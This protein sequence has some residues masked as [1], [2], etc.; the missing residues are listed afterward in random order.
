MDVDVAVVW[1]VSVVE[2][3]NTGVTVGGEKLHVAPTGK[4][5]VQL[6]ETA[7]LNPLIEVTLIVS[8][9]L[10]PALIVSE[11]KVAW[12]EKSGINV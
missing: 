5:D 3:M 1:T 4:P 10:S 6:N 11:G 2:A 9:A 12:I 7:P 8:K